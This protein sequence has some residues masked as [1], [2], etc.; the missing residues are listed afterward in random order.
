MTIVGPSHPCVPAYRSAPTNALLEP[1]DHAFELADW[2]EH[3]STSSASID[4]RAWDDAYAWLRVTSGLRAVSFDMAYDDDGM[5]AGG[6]FDL[7]WSDMM[8]E[9]QLQQVRLGY[10]T[11]A[12]HALARALRVSDPDIASAIDVAES[13]LGLREPQLLH[14]RVL[15]EHLGAHLSAAGCHLT[16]VSSAARAAVE[17]HRMAS[18][19][20][21]RVPEPAHDDAMN[22]LPGAR[23][24]ICA[25]REATSAL[26]L[27]GQVLLSSAMKMGRLPVPNE[28]KYLLDG[29]WVHKANGKPVWVDSEI[30]Y[31]EYLA[32]LHLEHG[33]PPAR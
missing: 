5:C 1:H 30:P 20:E 19:G 4:L 28:D 16:S 21:A 10:A 26:L 11:A 13:D 6:D 33:E 2:L 14:V 27:G 7:V 32:F 3:A 31:G 23:D 9:W 18:R 17:L 12:I 24:E 25:S 29:M 22:S 15:G 8:N